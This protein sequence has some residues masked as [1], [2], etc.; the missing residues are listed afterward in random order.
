MFC[1]S[2]YP[3]PCSPPPRGE[4]GG[5]L[6]AKSGRC[7][8]WQATCRFPQKSKSIFGET[9]FKRQDMDKPIKVLI[10]DDSAFNRRTLTKLL[11]SVRGV[12]VVG[13][14]VDGC[15]GS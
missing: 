8:V 7:L 10:I 1:A 11:E 15:D 3:P 12:E 6:V 13:V 5:G 14:A 4:K 9:L 2:P